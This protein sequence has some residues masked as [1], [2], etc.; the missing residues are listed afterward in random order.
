[1]S[2]KKRK[3]KLNFQIIGK[4]KSECGIEKVKRERNFMKEMRFE[5]DSD[6]LVDICYPG[7]N[8]LCL[9]L[10]QL[11]LLQNSTFVGKIK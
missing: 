2:K 8:N 6:G 11:W 10:S 1:M 4:R 9:F 7:K 5:L 3:Q